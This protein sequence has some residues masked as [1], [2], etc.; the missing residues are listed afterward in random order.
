MKTIFPHVGLLLCIAGCGAE[1]QTEPAP[2][3]AA[4][5]AS[6]VESAPSPDLQLDD[7]DNRGAASRPHLFQ[8]TDVASKKVRAAM[9]SAPGSTHLVVSV[10]VDDKK[11]CTGFHYNLGFDSNPSG[12]QFVFAESNG[13]QLAIEKDDIE[14]LK[15][16]TLDFA[17]LKSGDEGFVF[18]N[19]NENVSLPDELREVK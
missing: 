15:G 6:L 19:P 13:I 9:A 16:T 3:P 4:A 7:S 10:D 17:T 14:F 18:R 8:L 5:S 2:K 12:E 11:Y 1:T